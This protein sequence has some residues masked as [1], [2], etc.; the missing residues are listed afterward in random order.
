M[1]SQLASALPIILMSTFA[2]GQ[3]PVAPAATPP[4]NM[5]PT[6]SAVFYAGP[7][8][9]AP[10]LIPGNPPVVREP[11]CEPIDGM[12]T[13]AGVV[14]ADGIPREMKIVAADYPELSNLALGLVNSD[15]FKPGMHDGIPA[16]VE[17]T[18]EI[19]LQT[20]AKHAPRGGDP[21]ANPL[22]LRA[23]PAQSLS[24]RSEPPTG[25]A[26]PDSHETAGLYKVGGNISAPVPLSAPV[27]EYSDEARKKGI[28]GVSLVGLIVDTNGM[29]QNVHMIRAIGSGLDAKAMEAV[30]KYR[31][32]PAMKDGRIPVPVQVNVQ[33]NFRLYKRW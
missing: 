5:Q 7:G 28:S 25:Q 30:R 17:V 32:K 11:E 9:T 1:C 31:F 2:A 20:C 4:V 29:P 19:G 6:T 23:H 15:K 24:V 21:E 33:V 22:T 8:V 13:L 10:E 16:S 3:Q 18:I 14:G 27:A 12:V 26:A